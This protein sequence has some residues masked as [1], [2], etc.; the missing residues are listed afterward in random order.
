MYKLQT[1]VPSVGLCWIRSMSHKS[2]AI[3][4]LSD[5]RIWHTHLLNK[6]FQPNFSDKHSP[7][8]WSGVPTAHHRNV[9]PLNQKVTHFLRGWN[10]VN[11]NEWTHK[12]CKKRRDAGAEICWAMISD[13]CVT[14]KTRTRQWWVGYTAGPLGHRCSHFC[15][16]MLHV[17]DTRTMQ[18]PREQF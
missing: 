10:R 9:Y 6:E 14:G 7:R 1:Y 17:N 2:K 16:W 11:V 15:K 12:S 8:L 5:A 18:K 3:I 13:F 4:A